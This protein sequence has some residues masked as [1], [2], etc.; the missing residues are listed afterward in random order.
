MFKWI[1]RLF[2]IG[3]I[4]LVI[5]GIMA[6][7]GEPIW[8]LAFLS[9]GMLYFG[10]AWVL[11]RAFTRLLMT[12]FRMKGA[13]LRDAL[14]TV[15]LIER[16]ERPNGGSG[17]QGA[18]APAIEAS[19]ASMDG[20]AEEEGEA[21]GPPGLEDDE[22]DEDGEVP[23]DHLFYRIEVTIKPMAQGTKFTHWEPGELAIVNED[24]PPEDIKESDGK[25]EG[26][27]HTLEIWEEGKYVRDE[28]MKFPGEQ[29]LRLLVS[30][31][32]GLRVGKFRYYF[33][34]FGRLEFSKARRGDR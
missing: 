5:G 21:D 27:I 31:P 2:V 24:A 1:F 8:W 13:P 33:E 7:F 16:A 19:H 4:G 25:I 10:E 9:A 34:D 26:R 32:P 28:G 17:K 12:P 3:V 29:R 23:A 15:H 11:K 20:E 30:T 6:A 14:A 22:D 18:G